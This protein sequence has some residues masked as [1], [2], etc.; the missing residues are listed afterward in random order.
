MHF[1]LFLYHLLA[2][3]SACLFPLPFLPTFSEEKVGPKDFRFVS[4]PANN[5]LEGFV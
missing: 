1:S 3:I 4:L 5:V 2:I